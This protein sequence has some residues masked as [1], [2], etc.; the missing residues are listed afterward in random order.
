MKS[1]DP[2]IKIRIVN[3]YLNSFFQ[4]QELESEA[5][6]YG[7]DQVIHNSEIHMIKTIRDSGNEHVT[8]IAEYLGVTRGAVSQIVGKL[9]KKGLVERRIDPENN[10]RHILNLTEKGEAAN[11]EHMRYHDVINRVFF[12]Y[13]SRIDEDA[14]IALDEFFKVVPS[15]L[16]SINL[17]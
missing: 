7:T 8:A 5:R 17:E 16:S 1:N 12:E 3:N 14:A 15:L 10:S 6:N 4:F 13:L 2:D 11:G 9:E